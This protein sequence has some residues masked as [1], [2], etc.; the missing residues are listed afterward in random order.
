MNYFALDIETTGL[1][2]V[3]DQILEVGL[4]YDN[5]DSIESLPFL[6]IIIHHEIVRGHIT[7]LLMNNTLLKAC[8][9]SV[10]R[11]DAVIPLVNDWINGLARGNKATF[12]GKNLSS[13]DLPFLDNHAKR[14]GQGL[15]RYHR[16]VLDVGSMWVRASDTEV[17][18]LSTCLSRAGKVSPVRHEALS[19][20]YN[21]VLCVRAFMGE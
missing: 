20:C 17:P 21:I 12:A 15:Y 6:N 8:Y 3:D 14:H 13:F 9:E 7:A 1:N 5:G 18:D 11:S 19:D 4:V 2:R 10:V 16:R